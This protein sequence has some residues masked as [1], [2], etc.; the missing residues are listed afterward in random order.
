MSRRRALTST[1]LTFVALGL[2]GVA[3]TSTTDLPQFTLSRRP[4]ING[5]TDSSHQSVVALTWQGQQFC[6]GTVIAPRVI[7]SA[8]HCLVEMANEAQGFSA[9]AVKIFFGTT[10]GSSGQSI[11]VVEAHAH[12]QYY[13]RNDGA[14]MYD[15]SV[16]IMA[17][18]APVPPMAWQ[19]TPLGSVTGK[20]VTLVGYGVTNAYQQTGNGTRRTVS[21]TITD[22][23]NLF[24]YYGDGYSGTC[25][26]DSGGPMF[27][28]VNGVETVIG[29]TSFGDQSCVQQGANARTD[30][31]ADFILQYVATSGPTT[32]QPVSV[33]ISAPGNGATV[34]S[35]FG[36]TATVTSSA[37]V[38]K[39]ELLL[40]GNVAQ[41]VTS[42]PYNFSLTNVAAG[43]HQVTVRGTGTDGG[44]GQ[45]S[46][47]VTVQAGTTPITGCS[48]QNPCQTG[49]SCVNGQ[50][51]AQQP[52][53][54][55]T[56]SSDCVAGFQCVDS[57]CVPTLSSGA[58]GSACTHNSDC[59]SGM[60]VDG[61]TDHGF[62]TEEC[63]NDHDC[64]S[65][66]TCQSIA[67][68]SL[69]GPPVAT[70]NGATDD[71]PAMTGGCQASGSAA[72]SSSALALL[73]LGL[74][75]FR[76]R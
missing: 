26:G 21:A 14:P 8:G 73:L 7:L 46:I 12:P 38:Q 24:L 60:C 28:N 76:R 34:A 11:N 69:C 74:A 47:T 64:P 48:A 55:C 58:T 72:G 9:T 62:C 23:D 67:G 6:T 53:S 18:D 27:L 57:M 45:A 56:S 19:Q 39:A 51:V 13:L 35:S 54:G 15:T 31:L 1:I 20:T 61:D 52:T 16:W 63:S 3:C 4:I 44:T 33:S 49:Y 70:G 75:L 32:P 5:S 30:A 71:G 42:Q 22:V 43:S 66:A 37:G 17:Q 25:Q 50:C 36:V 10:V 59:D 2:L 41:T 29:V 68:M 40:D 65:G